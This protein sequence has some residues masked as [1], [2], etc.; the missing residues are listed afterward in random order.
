[1]GNKAQAPAAPTPAAPAPANPAIKPAA[2]P[3]PA[4]VTPPPAAAEASKVEANKDG[5][6]PGEEV[7]PAQLAAHL[8]KERVQRREAMLAKAEALANESK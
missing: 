7:S 6:T 8:A 5:F 3:A 2:T 1:M 4:A